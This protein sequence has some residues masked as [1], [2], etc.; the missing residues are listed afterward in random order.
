MRKRQR[1]K[2]RK[3]ERKEGEGKREGHIERGTD[4][5]TEC[6]YFVCE[7]LKNCI[8]YV[9]VCTCSARVVIVEQ[10]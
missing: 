10:K 9:R 7:Y 3:R 8:L 6:L 4:R 2:E 1:M 5:D